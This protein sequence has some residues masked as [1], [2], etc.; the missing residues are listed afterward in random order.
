[1]GEVSNPDVD[2]LCTEAPPPPPQPTVERIARGLAGS[3]VQRLQALL[4]IRSLNLSRLFDLAES[5][6]DAVAMDM[7]KSLSAE[8]KSSISYELSDF[9]LQLLAIER[10]PLAAGRGG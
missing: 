3:D 8:D 6:M 10:A 5:G 4:S 1:M 2:L 9:A 7:V